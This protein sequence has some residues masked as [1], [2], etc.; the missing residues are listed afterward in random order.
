MATN[1]TEYTGPDWQPVA[2]G[3][4]SFDIEIS[5]DFFYA[6]GATAPEPGAV[7]YTGEGGKPMP[8]A[9]TMIA[10]RNFYVRPRGVGAISAWRA[11]VTDRGAGVNVLS[12]IGWDTVKYPLTFTKK[13]GVWQSNFNRTAYLPDSAIVTTYYVD[14]VTGTSGGDGLSWATAK[15]AVHQAIT[16]ANATNQPAKIILRAGQTFHRAMGLNNSGAVLPA[17]S[18]YLTVEGGGRATIGL[19]DLVTYTASGSAWTTNLVNVASVWDILN[20]D[21]NGDNIRMVRLADEAAVEAAQRPE[22]VKVGGVYCQNGTV[23]TVKRWD[24]Q[25]VTNT[26]T[27]VYRRQGQP[28]VLGTAF[29]DKII[30]AENLDI[31][32][33]AG[34]S[35]AMVLSTATNILAMLKNCTLKYALDEQ[36]AGIGG[37]HDGVTH[38][39]TG[40]VFCDGCTFAQ[41]GKDAVN[42]SGATKNYVLTQ[43]CTDRALGLIAANGS[44]NAFTGHKYSV[45]ISVGDNW[46]E[47]EGPTVGFIDDTKFLILG[48]KVG[49]DRSGRGFSMPQAVCCLDRAVG[50]LIDVVT[51]VTTPATDYAI[52]A[53]DASA[54]YTRNVS[55]GG[56]LISGALVMPTEIY[57]AA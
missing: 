29:S 47:S 24:G 51:Q 54:V 57:V 11:V 40:L 2:A 6:Y 23:T 36:A 22:G 17:V 21:A 3:A 38:L 25:A 26:N 14:V 12:L 45:M 44:N 50:Y 46:T 15:Q 42:A 49:P 7:G 37:A 10:G 4:G 33:G 30:Y 39:G 28:L 41:L 8:L 9:I 27:R 48:S 1:V 31:E 55:T 53:L 56:A 43:G 18:I 32:G 16:A 52:R 5:T 34:N 13:S 20:K 35:C 19:H